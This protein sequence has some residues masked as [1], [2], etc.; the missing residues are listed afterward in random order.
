MGVSQQAATT[1]ED[2]PLRARKA[3]QTKLALFEAMMQALPD[4]SFRF[5]RVTDLCAEV[6]ISE[7]TFF[8]YFEKKSDLLVYAIMLWGIETHWH[9]RR[10]EPQRSAR[11]ST[12]WVFR[13]MAKSTLKHRRLTAELLARQALRETPPKFIDPSLAERL[14]RFP[15]KPGIEDCPAEGIVGIFTMLIERAHKKGELPKKVDREALLLSL[16]SIL[17]GVPIL[18]LWRNPRRIGPLYSQQ[19][20]MVFKAYE[21][22]S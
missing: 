9:L 17:W 1:F 15:G 3:A 22:Q 19:L 11:E 10:M 4:S 5:I 20:E 12:E 13:E 18:K 2:L 16:I 6:G 14:L 8:S 21:W 7:P